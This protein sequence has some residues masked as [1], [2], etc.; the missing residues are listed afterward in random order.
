MQDGSLRVLDV[1]PSGFRQC[2]ANSG[3]IVVQVSARRRLTLLACFAARRRTCAC[4]M[5]QNVD[6]L[7]AHALSHQA[8]PYVHRVDRGRTDAQSVC[9]GCCT[10]LSQYE[11]ENRR[12]CA[13]SMTKMVRILI[14][15]AL[16]HQARPYLH[17]MACL[18]S[19]CAVSLLIAH[20]SNMHELD[21]FLTLPP[22]EN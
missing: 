18:T 2:M 20:F 6:I 8:S 12:I 15:H 13:C 21:V 11:G 17:M 19:P 14:T 1:R 7:S 10:V 22:K 4:Q 16:S 5:T 3:G 9:T